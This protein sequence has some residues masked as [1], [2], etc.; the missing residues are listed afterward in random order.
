MGATGANV[1]ELYGSDIQS[2]SHRKRAR[3]INFAFDYWRRTG[4]PYPR[5]NLEAARLEIRR[6]GAYNGNVLRETLSRPSMV[7]I[8]LANASH[9]EIWKAR[10]RGKSPLDVFW[11]DDALKR[12][13]TRACHLR[14]HRR[15]WCP[16]E[17][18]ML[19]S[20]H[21]RG[22]VSNFRPTV[23][24]TLADAF[25]NNKGRVLDFC[26]GYGGRYLG[27][28][29]LPRHYF[30]IDVSHIRI[31]RLTAMSNRL[32]GM[33][34]STSEFVVGQAESVLRDL[35]S[36]E[37]DLVLTSPPYFR[38]EHYDGSAGQCRYEYKS[39][40]DWLTHFL[41]V[42]LADSYRCLR[43]GGMLVV[44]VANAGRYPIGA[45]TRRII[46][47]V[48]GDSPRCLRMVMST[49][50]NAK[51]RDGRAYKSEPIYVVRKSF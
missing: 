3:L 38:H 14:P 49:N 16:S 13:L 51:A 22:R 2:C 19:L 9:P 44:N 18:R 48:F 41:V 25:S 20:L 40:Q 15:C 32:R 47:S 23:A 43:R 42:V 7:G 27:I 39:Y 5:T 45:D 34:P 17:L 33:L 10:V 6:L 4:F 36:R 12:V 35:P 30:G 8:G 28:G 46:Q 11:D 50:P 37:F 24:R 21:N 1:I 31:R 26:A 29:S